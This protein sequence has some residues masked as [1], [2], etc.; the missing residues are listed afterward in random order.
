MASCGDLPPLVLDRPRVEPV[1]A[2]AFDGFPVSDTP[3]DAPHMH[4][5]PGLFQTRGYM[6]SI[7][8]PLPRETREARVVGSAAGRFWTHRI[9]L[10]TSSYSVKRPSAR[11]SAVPR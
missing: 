2:P 3:V 1:E 4:V 5:V 11:F 10:N 8:G 9:R 7:I 6:S